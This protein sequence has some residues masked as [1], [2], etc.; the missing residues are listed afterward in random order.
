MQAVTGPGTT[1]PG[2]ESIISDRHFKL[3]C[4]HKRQAQL[5]GW[6]TC[7]VLFFSVNSPNVQLYADCGPMAMCLLLSEFHQRHFCTRAKKAKLIPRPLFGT[8]GKTGLGAFVGDLNGHTGLLPRVRSASQSAGWPARRSLIC[9]YCAK[10]SVSTHASKTLYAIPL[11]HCHSF[12]A[13]S[14]PGHLARVL[15]GPSLPHS[16]K[17]DHNTRQR[18]TLEL[19]HQSH[20]SFSLH[21]SILRDTIRPT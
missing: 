6:R 9:L 15:L 14:F 12:Q 16:L 1:V 11:S 8:N 17:T 2:S 10:S 7:C 21:F 18:Q 20:N 5:R 3:P 4:L 19:A 13:F